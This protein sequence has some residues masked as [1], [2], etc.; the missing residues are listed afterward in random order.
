MCELGAESL[1]ALSATLRMEL[2]SGDVKDC[3]HR[4][5]LPEFLSTYFCLAEVGWD[6]VPADAEFAA[7]GF[8]D[9]GSSRVWVCARTVSMGFAWS[10]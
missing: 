4:H 10:L 1:E 9:R 5:V 6:D 8:D 3:F 7:G 2:G